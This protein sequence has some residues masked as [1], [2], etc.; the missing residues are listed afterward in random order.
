M[1]WELVKGQDRLLDRN[2]FQLG[3]LCE[4]QLLQG[5][6]AHDKAGILGYGVPDGLGHKGDRSRC[7]GIGFNDVHLCRVCSVNAW[8]ALRTR[9]GHA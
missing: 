2:M 4:V 9:L 6:A 7:P 3:L 5:L 1:T 8:L